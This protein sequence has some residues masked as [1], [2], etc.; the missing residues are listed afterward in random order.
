MTIKPLINQKSSEE[1]NKEE[2]TQNN[3]PQ[4]EKRGHSSSHVYEENVGRHRRTPQKSCSLRKRDHKRTDTRGEREKHSKSPH[5]P[6]GSSSPHNNNLASAT[7]S[8]SST[9][10]V[11]GGV[12]E[13]LEE[14]FSGYNSGDEHIGQR[15]AE[16][17]PQEWTERDEKFVKAMTERGLIVKEIV[18]DG[19]CLFRAIS[20]QIYGDQDM[21]EVIRQQTLDYIY[22]NREYFA[23][24]VTEDIS[25]YVQ[26]KRQN[27]VH[28]NHIEIQAMSE[29]YNRPVELYCYQTKPINIF[30]SG[31]SDNGYEPL[32]LSYQRCSHYN[33]I[34]DPFKA[35]VGVGLGLAGYKPEELDLKQV[36]DAVRLSEDLEIEQTMFEDKLKTTDWEATNEAIEE[37]IARESYL[38]WCREQKAQKS[39]GSSSTVTSTAVSGNHLGAGSSTMMD[40]SGCS[41]SAESAS[42]RLSDSENGANSSSAERQRRRRRRLEDE[43]PV[44]E[45]GQRDSDLNYGKKAKRRPQSGSNSPERTP[46]STPGPSSRE[47]SPDQKPLSLFYQ[48]LLESSYADD[49]DM[50]MTE[51]EMIQKALHMSR[52]DFI[53]VRQKHSDYDSP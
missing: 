26:R 43:T 10:N 2:Q 30:N 51:K 53:K 15:D 11:S 47:E 27:H 45:S 8:H 28:G 33:A 7:T 3:S 42:S 19:A 9:T 6:L 46:T 12:M 35:S 50:Q 4:R 16:L 38:Q 5:F 23:Q 24:F 41:S 49:G 36:R 25:S 29:I 31:Q 22:Q 18:E 37:Q 48:S 20:L 1:G 34:L 32:R 21:H 14:S 39:S 52:V 40:L 44:Q 13:L 17:T